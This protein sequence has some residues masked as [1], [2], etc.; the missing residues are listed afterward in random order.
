M[1]ISRKEKKPVILTLID[2]ALIFSFGCCFS[3]VF[4]YSAGTWQGIT[5][6]TQL[7]AIR[8][9]LIA[10]L[11]LAGFS[12]YGITARI[13]FLVRRRSP[14]Y[15]GGL[16]VCLVSAAFGAAV[17]AAGTLILTAAGGNV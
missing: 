15:L 1:T 12:L 17:A 16:A 13:W 2:K 8:T 14:A 11:F 7:L 9:G 6:R 3:A 5:D 4:L 10:G